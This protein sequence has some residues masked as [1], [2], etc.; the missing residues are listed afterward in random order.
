MYNKTN[1]AAEATRYIS[2]CYQIQQTKQRGDQ[3]QQLRTSDTAQGYTRA[4]KDI[5][6]IRYKDNKRTQGEQRRLVADN[7]SILIH[8]TSS[9]PD[10]VSKFI[11]CI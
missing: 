8:L 3:R 7:S 10:S 11:Q 1:K 9:I 6:I 5:C 2:V 4:Y